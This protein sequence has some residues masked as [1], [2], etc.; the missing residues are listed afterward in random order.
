MCLTTFVWQAR[1]L[2][3]VYAS[4]LACISIIVSL[5]KFIHTHFPGLCS[6][7][8]RANLEL[9]VAGRSDWTENQS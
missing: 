4:S 7:G 3:E 8:P 9:V 6:F 1:M 2:G 5:C